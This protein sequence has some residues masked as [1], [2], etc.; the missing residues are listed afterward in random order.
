MTTTPSLSGS[1]AL[2]PT[3]LPWRL[4][5][6]LGVAA[7]GGLAWLLQD[8]L[9]VRGQAALGAVCLIGVIAAFSANLRAVSWRAVGWGVALQ[10]SLALFVLKFELYGLEWL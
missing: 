8:L 10:L 7:L 2:P 4:A 5:L 9:G 3:P 1:T 6:G